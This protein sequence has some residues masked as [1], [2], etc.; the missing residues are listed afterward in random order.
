[1]STTTTDS[2]DARVAASTS[3]NGFRFYTFRIWYGMVAFN[4]P[5]L[6]RDVPDIEQYVFDGM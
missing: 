2:W 5:A 6:A 3:Y 1:M 4:R